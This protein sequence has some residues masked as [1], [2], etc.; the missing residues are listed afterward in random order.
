M[1]SRAFP[2]LICL[3]LCSSAY[4]RSCSSV[5]GAVFVDANSDNVKAPSE[6]YVQGAKLTLV[7][8]NNVV[9]SS[10]TSDASGNF[11]FKGQFDNGRYSI[12]SPISPLSMPVQ[13]DR[14]DDVSNILYP[15]SSQQSTSDGGQDSKG[16]QPSGVPPSD[17][18]S[19]GSPSGLSKTH[20]I[21]IG[22]CVAAVVVAAVI[23]GIVVRRRRI[24]AR[25]QA[26]PQIVI[27]GAQLY[28]PPAAS[29]PPLHDDSSASFEIVKPAATSAV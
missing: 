22:S 28:S 21:I 19:G 9:V 11:E 6:K 17:Q 20:M 26:R 8:S 27:A 7:T 3:L 10:T 4:G 23:V 18:T 15:L 1:V 5:S 12:R 25:P 14:G 13:I 24:A 29:A 2:A 16:A